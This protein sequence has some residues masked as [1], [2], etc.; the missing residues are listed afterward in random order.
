MDRPRLPV[1]AATADNR[2]EFQ[3]LAI[4]PR[5]KVLYIEGSVRLEYKWTRQAFISDSN[6]ELAT[7]S[8]QDSNE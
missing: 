1:N 3:G 2:Q 8:P 7:F 6:I 5:I 4:D